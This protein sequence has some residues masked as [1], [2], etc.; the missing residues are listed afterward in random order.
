MVKLP[1][2]PTV[3]PCLRVAAMMFLRTWDAGA[4]S[5]GSG[6]GAKVKLAAESF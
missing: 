4:L 2:V 1:L 3:M 5:E 6:A